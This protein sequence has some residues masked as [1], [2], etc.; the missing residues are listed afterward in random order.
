MSFARSQLSAY[1]NVQSPETAEL[2]HPVAGAPAGTP[3]PV[4]PPSGPND[5]KLPLVL[6]KAP[7]HSPLELAVPVRYWFTPAAEAGPEVNITAGSAVIDPIA[8]VMTARFI[9]FIILPNPRLGD[10]LA[11]NHRKSSRDFGRRYFIRHAL[12][13]LQ[14]TGLLNC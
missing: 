3:P 2:F 12:S 8:I 9:L 1:P 4:L 5:P 11:Q 13:I 14:R 6:A 7:W 10:A